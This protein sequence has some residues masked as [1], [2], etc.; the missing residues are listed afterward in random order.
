MLICRTTRCPP[1]TAAINQP[2]IIEPGW[3]IYEGALLN[4]HTGIGRDPGAHA[5]KHRAA[6]VHFNL[7][8]LTFK[9]LHPPFMKPI[10]SAGEAKKEPKECTFRVF[11]DPL[12]SP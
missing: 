8:P 3:E 4:A 10:W 1:S 5:H 9:A 6:R 7:R 2:V 12:L 11:L